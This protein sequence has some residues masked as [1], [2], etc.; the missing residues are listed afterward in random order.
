MA[1]PVRGKVSWFEVASN[2][3]KRSAE[4]YGEVFGW[5]FTGDSGVYLAA[6]PVDNGIAG[7]L[8]PAAPEAGTYATFGVEVDNVD[9]AYALA[10]TKGATSVVPPTDNPGGVRSAYLRDVDGSLFAIYRFGAPPP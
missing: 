2:D 4:F 3:V 7:G 9:D 6:S 1:G 5:T 10:L 8:I